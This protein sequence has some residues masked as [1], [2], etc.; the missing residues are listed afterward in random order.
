MLL[1]IRPLRSGILAPV[2]VGE[3][4]RLLHRAR[5]G[6]PDA[7]GGLLERL[8]PRV[9]FWVATR[10]PRGLRAKLEPDDVAQQVLFSVYEHFDRFEGG[11]LAA[12]HGWL[13]K[14]AENQILDLHKHFDAKKRRLPEPRPFHQTTPS[15]AAARND[16]IARMRSML[17]GL[18]DRFRDILR[19]RSLEERSYE[20]CADALDRSPSACR[21]LLT[22]ALNALRDAMEAHDE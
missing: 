14:I 9:L 16:E 11:D 17:E 10:L 20:Y 22:R 2:G 13:F 7:L 8:R 6:G 21:T 19:L 12:F 4:A 3:T 5:D 18:P 1:R 15:Q